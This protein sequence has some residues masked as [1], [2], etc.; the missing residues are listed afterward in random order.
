MI[1]GSNCEPKTQG[2]LLHCTSGQ[3]GGTGSGIKCPYVCV[4]TF[5]RGYS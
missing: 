1:V 5:L 3:F 2:D 4:R